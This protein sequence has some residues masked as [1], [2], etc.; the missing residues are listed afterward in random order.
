MA[1]LKTS[2]VKEDWKEGMDG[3]VIGFEGLLKAQRKFVLS[4]Q[5]LGKALL[6]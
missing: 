6:E 1:T 4:Y 2:R 3:N 5:E